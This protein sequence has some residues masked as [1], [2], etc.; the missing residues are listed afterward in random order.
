MRVIPFFSALSL[1]LLAGCKVGPDYRVP[2][3]DVPLTYAEDREGLTS[4]VTDDDLVQWWTVLND[5]LLNELLERS[6]SGSFD[7]RIALE[8]ICQARAQFRISFAEIF[9]EFV[10]DF[11][12][13][14]YRTSQSFDSLNTPV[15]TLGLRRPI[16]DFFQI[17]IDAIWEIDFFGKFRRAADSS[18]DLWEASIADAQAVRITVLSEVAITYVNIRAFQKKIGIQ[19]QFID[20]ADNLV[21]FSQLKLNAGLD[22]AQTMQQLIATAEA[23]RA[24]LTQLETGLRQSIYSL[25]ILLGDNPEELLEYFQDVGPIP[26]AMCMV[27]PAGIPADLLRRRPDIV[28][29]E[30][31]LA[32]ATE[33]IGVAVAEL[34]PS[35]SLAGSSSTFASNPLQG[36]NY[37]YAS[38]HFRKL[39]KPA[40][41][42]WGIGAFVQW[43]VFD[44]GRRA[45]NVCVYESIARQSYLNYQKTIV[46]ALAE[47]EKA[48]I[49]YF[50]EQERLS[51]LFKEVDATQDFLTLN[52]D[53]F[54]SGLAD[55]S[56]V[57]QTQ[58]TWLSAQMALID[59]QQ[60]LTIDLIGIYKALGGDW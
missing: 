21:N 13:T 45:S 46:A 26:Y 1:L 6:I 18:Y 30:R 22:N 43:P 2:D 33:N 4:E 48:L 58:E 38:D 53:L 25:A 47:T 52:Q 14:H 29:A 60:A 55:F 12:G 54:Q 41:R 40:S 3:V 15:P 9:P 42:I 23:N 10:G 34:F 44:F 51:Y 36:A 19:R 35:V 28:N 20:Y 16:Q 57:L 50:N 39:F 56:L 32:S 5:P 37:G 31:Q 24:T 7:Y 11:L 27:P 59:S 8:K 49:A 17:G